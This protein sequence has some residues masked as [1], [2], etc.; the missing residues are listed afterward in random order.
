VRRVIDIPAE[1]LSDLVKLTDSWRGNSSERGFSMALS[2]LG[3][4]TTDPHCVV[5]TGHI[6]GL[7]RGLLQFVP[8]GVED[9]SLDLM[10]REDSVPDN[11][12]NELM[13][14][15]LLGA[16]RSLG[17]DQ[18]S[19]NFAVFRSAL[20]RGERIGAGPIAR[21]WARLLRVASR[22]WQIETLYRFNAKF[23]PAW[24][25]RFLVFDA[26]RDLPRIAIAAFEAEGYG[27]VHRPYYASSI[28]HEHRPTR[29][30]GARDTAHSR[31]PSGVLGLVRPGDRCGAT[32]GASHASTSGCP[33]KIEEPVK[34]PQRG[35]LRHSRS[36]VQ[37]HHARRCDRDPE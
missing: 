10:I 35:P 20:D 33:V 22:W 6:D 31:P 1:E 24:V 37:H 23:D 12:L 34:G 32:S 11:G 21:L 16:S 14:A 26:A 18:V 25:P 4:S 27:V 5:V 30:I 9:L 8:W 17:V 2:R 13:I 19:M 15:E 36:P 29:H 28:A 3:E 7:V